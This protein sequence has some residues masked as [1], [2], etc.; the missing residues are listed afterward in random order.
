MAQLKIYVDHTGVTRV[1]VDD[2]RISPISMLEVKINQDDP[3]PIVNITFPSVEVAGS[4]PAIL[5]K[6][7]YVMVDYET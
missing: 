3:L 7:P 1:F 4:S 6:I 5:A 2:E